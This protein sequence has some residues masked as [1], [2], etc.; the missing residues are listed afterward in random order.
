MKKI[1]LILL[2]FLPLLAF[3]QYTG[4]T[5]NAVTHMRYTSTSGVTPVLN[6][7]I[8]AGLMINSTDSS[9]YIWTPTNPTW[10]LFLSS[11][12]STLASGIYLPA[13]TATGG[14][15]TLTSDSATWSRIGNIVT[16]HGRLSVTPSSGTTTSTFTLSLPVNSHFY[17][18]DACFGVL[19][20][21]ATNNGFLAGGVQCGVAGTNTAS[22]TVAASG[23]TSAFEVYYSY[24][25]QVQ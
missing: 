2:G 20:T 8:E 25:Y 16:V 17:N 1:A 5:A 18:G 23:Q 3:A 12:L 19:T 6:G 13:A 9:L 24:Q 14:L 11:N 15:T 22:V 10:R 21:S 7:T 4:N